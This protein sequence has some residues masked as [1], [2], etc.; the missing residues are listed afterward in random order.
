MEQEPPS[1]GAEGIAAE[2]KKL[3]ER[4]MRAKLSTLAYLLDMTQIEAETQA[5][6][7]TE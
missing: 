5:R 4:A 7:G 3:R 6:K 1:D 2:L